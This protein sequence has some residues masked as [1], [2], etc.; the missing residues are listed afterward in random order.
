MKFSIVLS[1]IG[2]VAIAACSM[3]PVE[4]GGFAIDPSRPYLEVTF[5]HLGPRVPVRAGESSKGVWLRFLNNC[6]YEVSLAVL[7]LRNPN[8]GQLVQ[9]EVIRAEFP[10]AADEPGLG[11]SPL[12]SAVG[13][14]ELTHTP[15]EI[16]IEPGQ[17]VL[18]S[19]PVEHISPRTF[20]R[21]VPRIAF[22]RIAG[23]DH[24]IT[25]V[26]FYWRGLPSDVADELTLR[27]RK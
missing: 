3:A 23:K 6:P 24:P 27:N 14:R 22:P 15:R 25:L 8:P 7:S 16:E 4:V 9:Y 5:D 13:Y 18:F 26:E 17:S 11:S 1:S 21:V 12:E 20:L 10:D 2:I 19:V